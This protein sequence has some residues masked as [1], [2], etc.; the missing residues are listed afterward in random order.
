VILRNRD[1]TSAV[2]ANNWPQLVR[3]ADKTGK[4]Q[5]QW[6]FRTP[7]RKCSVNPLETI[8]LTLGRGEGV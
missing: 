3:F 4:T 2:I 5:G 7:N 6:V 1:P 8:R